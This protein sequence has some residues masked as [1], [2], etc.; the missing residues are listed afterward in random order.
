MD[1]GRCVPAMTRMRDGGLYADIMRRY[2]A[3]RDFLSYATRSRKQ[4]EEAAKAL[5][6]EADQMFNPI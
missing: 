1:L 6:A 4:D 2:S 5:A 3:Y